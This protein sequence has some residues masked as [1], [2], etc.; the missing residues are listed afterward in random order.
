MAAFGVTF[1]LDVTYR[2]LPTWPHPVTRSR[3]GRPFKAS[4]SQTLTLLERELLHLEAKQVVVGIGLKE[5]DIRLDG[6]PRADAREPMHPGVELSFDSMHGR[7]TYPTDVCSHWQQNVRSI[8]L[9]LEAL[10]AVDRYGVSKQGQQ[11]AGWKELPSGLG[12]GVIIASSDE[13]MEIL[14]EA[15]DI[16][17]GGNIEALFREAARRTHPDHGGDTE[18]FLRVQAAYELLKVMS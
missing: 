4:W 8:A 12:R 7:L 17:D 6:M 14:M 9:G 3:R 13:A 18:E 11:Y 10:R 2:P 1:R 15:A 5:S 16:F